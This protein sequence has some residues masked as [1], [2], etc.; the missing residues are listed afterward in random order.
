MGAAPIGGWTGLASEQRRQGSATKQQPG[1][2]DGFVEA[3][4]GLSCWP[5]LKGICV[6]GFQCRSM[7]HTA[8][9]CAAPAPLQV[10]TRVAVSIKQVPTKV[11]LGVKALADA[12]EDK[13]LIVGDV[14]PKPAAE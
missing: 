13:S 12:E 2:V 9:A 4:A 6:A 3:A 14:L 10:P 7:W 11:A 5:G 8:L 1:L